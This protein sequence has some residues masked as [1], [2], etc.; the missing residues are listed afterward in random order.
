MAR[1]AFQADHLAHK[2]LNREPP[3]T[4]PIGTLLRTA[5]SNNILLLQVLYSLLDTCSHSLR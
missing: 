1:R 3:V 4:F 2:S 5:K